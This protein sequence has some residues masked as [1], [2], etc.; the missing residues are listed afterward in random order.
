MQSTGSVDYQTLRGIRNRQPVLFKFLSITVSH[1]TVR[2]VSS[3]LIIIIIS[4]S[5]FWI[6]Q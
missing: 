2:L 5:I 1:L 4:F 3:R 6:V